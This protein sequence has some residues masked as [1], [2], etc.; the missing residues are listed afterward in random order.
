MLGVLGLGFGGVG[1][2]GL[3]LL[4]L[5]YPL[6]RTTR[7]LFKGAWRDLNSVVGLS[8][9]QGRV[10]YVLLGGEVGAAIARDL[11]FR[12]DWPVWGFM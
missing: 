1:F 6:L 4:Y 8:G 11:A 5:N 10:Q 2:T 7:T 12:V 9:W 3:G